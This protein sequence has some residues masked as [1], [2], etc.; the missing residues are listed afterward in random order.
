M[1]K[2]NQGTEKIEIL[3]LKVK[4]LTLGMKNKF[5]KKRR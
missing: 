3:N 4:I 1:L 5:P 2:G